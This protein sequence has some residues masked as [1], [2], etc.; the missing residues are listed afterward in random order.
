MRSELVVAFFSVG[1][2]GARVVDLTTIARFAI[3][4]IHK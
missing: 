1:G 4:F 2:W 3:F